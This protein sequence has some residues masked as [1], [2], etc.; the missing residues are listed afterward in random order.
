MIDV[1][2]GNLLNL[3]ISYKPNSSQDLSTRSIPSFLILKI[4]SLRHLDLTHF[5]LRLVL[6][7]L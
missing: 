6:V 2:L 7:W 3:S 4:S 1:V 5:A